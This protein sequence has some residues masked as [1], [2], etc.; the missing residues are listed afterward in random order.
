MVRRCWIHEGHPGGHAQA[1]QINVMRKSDLGWRPRH[2]WND[3]LIRW[4]YAMEE[5]VGPKE[6]PHKRLE[7]MEISL[8]RCLRDRGPDAVSTTNYKVHVAEALERLGRFEDASP[9]RRE[10][11]SN[12]E[13]Y[14][15]E[16]DRRT[17]REGMRLAR[18]LDMTGDTGEAKQLAD[19]VHLIADRVLHGLF[20]VNAT[21]C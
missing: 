14:L 7:R 1:A 21:G 13:R 16:E 15:G 19:H 18:N 5:R 20:I 6:D 11:F 2:W 9:L 4:T 17:L 8:N 3:L 10:V 12:C